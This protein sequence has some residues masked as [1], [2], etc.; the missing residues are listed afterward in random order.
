[1]SVCPA[2]SR[3]N[4]RRA[5]VGEVGRVGAHVEGRAACQQGIR[6]GRPAVIGQRSEFWINP[7]ARHANEIAIAIRRADR[8]RRQAGTRVVAYE[9]VSKANGATP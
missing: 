4:P 9:T 3:R 5:V 1:M 2:N 6:L 8:G 7:A